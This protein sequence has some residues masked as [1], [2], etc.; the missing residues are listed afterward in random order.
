[1]TS[2]GLQPPGAILI[3]VAVNIAEDLKIALIVDTSAAERPALLAGRLTDRHGT[4]SRNGG[5]L[6]AAHGSA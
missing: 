6:P 4:K 5:Q 1:L 2:C 3:K